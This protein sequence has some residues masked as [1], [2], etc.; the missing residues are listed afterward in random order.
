MAGILIGSVV[1]FA[2]VRKF[3]IRLV[4]I[5]FPIEKIN[6]LKFLKNTKSLNTTAF[7]VFF[8]PGTPKDLLT[9]LYN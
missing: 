8:I 5:F 9:Y 2:F 1:I 4:E 7:I 3:G 6:S